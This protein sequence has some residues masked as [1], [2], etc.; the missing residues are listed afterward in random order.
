MSSEIGTAIITHLEADIVDSLLFRDHDPTNLQ[1]LLSW[2]D[3]D[4]RI[5]K[6]V[7]P[8]KLLV[9][10]I[11]IQEISDSADD[12]AP[13]YDQDLSDDEI[14][15]LTVISERAEGRDAIGLR[16]KDL[17]RGWRNLPVQGRTCFW[18]T[19]TSDTKDFDRSTN[20]HREIIRYRI[21]SILNP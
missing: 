12:K 3:I 15:Q 10:S 14:W 8:T 9:P 5:Y 18:W 17:L 2:T 20:T 16:V 6:I 21:R 4:L 13:G 7:R 1:T 11:V 19:R